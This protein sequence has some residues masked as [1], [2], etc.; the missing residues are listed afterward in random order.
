MMKA[1]ANKQTRNCVAL[2]CFVAAA[3]ICAIGCGKEGP[4]AMPVPEVT[5]VQPAKQPV[6][7]FLEFTGNAQA[8]DTV[9]LQ[10]R[11]SGFLT[12]VN[13]KDGDWV[14]QG[15]LLFEIEPELYAARLALAEA[16]V[17]SAQAELLRAT[18]EYNRQADLA[19]QKA[20]AVSEVD[21]WRAQRD[22]A[23]AKLDQAK[24]EVEIGRINLSYTQVRAPFDGRLDRKLKD[25]GNLVGAGEPT[26]LTTIYHMNP[27]YAYFSINEKDFVKVRAPRK[28][29]DPAQAVVFAGTEGEDGYPHQGV[30][31]FGSSSLDPNTG[32][33]LL[34]GVFDNPAFAEMPKILPGMFVRLRVPVGQREQAVLV[35]DQALGVDQGGRYVLTVTSQEI[36]D[37]KPVKTGALVNGLRVI[38]Q[39]LVGDES[40][41]VAGLQQARPGA[42]VKPVQQEAQ[43]SAPQKTSSTQPVT[44]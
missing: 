29:G 44:K 22:S 21:K 41:I 2:F 16:A 7:D 17:V 40:V 5:V 38:E 39:G 1:I 20:V 4:K 14:K 18:I 25:A 11:V 27:I 15:D 34:R 23:Q 42:K 28:D 33:L 43:G 32:T 24:S 35:P 6:T 3:A 8:S 12:K 31:D 13:F 19:K 36:V 30:I 37:K 26:L 10:A 9:Q